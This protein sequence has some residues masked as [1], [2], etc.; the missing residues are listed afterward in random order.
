[1][2]SIKRLFDKVAKENPNW[3]SVVV[4]NHIVSGKNFTHDRIVRM[5]NVLVDED[6]YEKSEKKAILK[7]VYL[8]NTPFNRTKNGGI[9]PSRDE[10]ILKMGKDKSDT[11]KPVKSEKTICKKN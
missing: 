3:G 2:K 1:M 5:F 6:E 8:V 9:L 7:D 11:N 10:K 4:F